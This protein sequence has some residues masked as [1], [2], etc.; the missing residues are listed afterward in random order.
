VASDQCPK[1]NSSRRSLPQTVS[2]SA[3]SGAKLSASDTTILEN[4]PH[5]KLKQKE[6]DLLDD[7]VS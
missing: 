1:D 3:T 5:Q 4:Q 7:N 2:S 6:S